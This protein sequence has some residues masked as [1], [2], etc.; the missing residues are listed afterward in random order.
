MSENLN[1]V[2]LEVEES[3]HLLVDQVLLA[4]AC[5]EVAMG[6]M[7]DSL[8]NLVQQILLEMSADL[9]S[10]VVAM[11]Q[12]GQWLCWREI[13]QLDLPPGFMASTA[14]KEDVFT[15]SEELSASLPSFAHLMMFQKSE[16]N[17]CP[18]PF[19]IKI[20]KKNQCFKGKI[21]KCI[22]NT[23]DS[24]QSIQFNITGFAEQV[25]LKCSKQNDSLP[26]GIELVKNN[27]KFKG[28]MN[29]SYAGMYMCVASY[30]HWKKK[31][32]IT[33]DESQWIPTRAVLIA[34]SVSFAASAC[35]CYVLRWHR[36]QQL[37]VIPQQYSVQNIGYQTSRDGL[38]C[39]KTQ[40]DARDGASNVNTPYNSQKTIGST[41][42]IQ[43]TL[44]DADVFNAAKQD[45]KQNV[46]SLKLD[47]NDQES[48]V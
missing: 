16:V 25:N 40:Q 48:A 30:Q 22:F 8:E 33:S 34:I 10:I 14:G 19:D 28:P 29:E 47:T 12:L 5:M 38:H 3:V 13:G 21:K 45:S 6:R 37:I 18:G 32:E 15:I 39:I 44:G 9:N 36:R 46:K 27:L 26:E 24:E 31:I 35:F 2:A 23:T 17:D 20:K 11:S 41:N 1:M 42:M 7:A 43:E 4:C